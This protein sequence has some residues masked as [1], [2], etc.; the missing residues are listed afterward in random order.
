MSTL[1]VVKPKAPTALKVLVS[2]YLAHQ[3]GRGLSPRTAALTAN[4]L[5]RTFLPWCSEHGLTRPDQLTQRAVD[6]FQGDLLERK[7]ARESVRTYVR[8]IATFVRWAGDEFGKVKLKQPKAERKVVETLSRDEVARIENAAVSER[9][10]I[11]IRLLADTGIRLGELLGLRRSDLIEQGRERY[12]KVRGK[13]ARERLVPLP[14]ALFQRLRRYA[15]RGAGERIFV[16]NRRSPKTG[17]YEPVQPRSVQ[18]M[19]KFT[20]EAAG[21]TRRVH[22]HLFRHS[23]ATHAL[24]R[25]MNPLQLQRILGHADLTM[26]SSTYSHLTASDAFGALMSALTAED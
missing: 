11:I 18:N 25:G 19:L 20:A 16:T 15:G 4:V 3:R 23:F 26:I 1:R 12:I 17:D 5:E 22:P 8:T 2:D 14:P 7:L 13:G 9:D 10:Q 24:R 6:R 21:I